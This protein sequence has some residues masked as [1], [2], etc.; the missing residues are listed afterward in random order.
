MGS[1]PSSSFALRQEGWEIVQ[2]RG[3]APDN[4]IRQKIE[5]FARGDSGRP[6]K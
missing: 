2:R 1:N 4:F 3:A 5:E 6:G